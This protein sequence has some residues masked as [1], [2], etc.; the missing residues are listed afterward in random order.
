MLDVKD[1]V[2]QGEE[3]T[4]TKVVGPEDTV[5]TSSTH[6]QQLLSTNACINIMIKTAVEIVDPKLPPGYITVGRYWETT[7]HAPVLMG[8]TVNFKIVLDKID[9]NRLLFSM[10]GWDDTGEFCRAK[11]E[12]VVINKDKLM[13]KVRERAT[14]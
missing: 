9:G 4:I 11:H 14:R 10:T 2:K 3:V 1:F 8:S 6:L 12:R 13:D 5:G 7:H